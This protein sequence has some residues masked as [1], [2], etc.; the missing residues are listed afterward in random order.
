M[1]KWKEREKEL[2]VKYESSKKHLYANYMYIEE[3]Q[4]ELKKCK[5]WRDAELKEILEL[6]SNNNKDYIKISLIKRMIKQMLEGDE[7]GK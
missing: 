3:R 5:Q 4:D 1:N 2:K 6:I 7:N